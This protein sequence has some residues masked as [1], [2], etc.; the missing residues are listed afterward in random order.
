MTQTESKKNKGH[1]KER[2][3]KIR[4]TPL[5]NNAWTET[6]CSHLKALPNGG[7]TLKYGQ[8]EEYDR[9]V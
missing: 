3:K 2:R 8:C 5:G 7:N 6:F 9:D 4:Q 1:L